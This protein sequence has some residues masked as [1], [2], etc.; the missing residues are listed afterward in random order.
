M[1][2]IT[3]NTTPISEYIN[4][5]FDAI[6]TDGLLIITLCVVWYMIVDII[7][8]ELRH[9]KLKE[10]RKLKEKVTARYENDLN[11]SSKLPFNKYKKRS[12]QL[13]DK[14]Y[15]TLRKLKLNNI[16]YY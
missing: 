8:Q 2:I 11:E 14:Y 7:E 10:D 13:Q 5:F 6:G 9:K 4:R 12:K 15:N 1:A 16:D 3:I